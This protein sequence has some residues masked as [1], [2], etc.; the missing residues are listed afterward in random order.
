MIVR[1]R[2]GAFAVAELDRTAYVVSGTLL[3]FDGSAGTLTRRVVDIPRQQ[4][5]V[6]KK[7]DTLLL[8]PESF[9]GRL[10]VLDEH[11]RVLLPARIGVT[12]PEV[13]R[14]VQPG[15]AIWFDDGKIGVSC[16]RWIRSRSPWRSPTLD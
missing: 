3:R 15:E 2:D 16:G 4:T 1:S 8:T 11:D 12:L 10:A 5:L 9:A 6:L 7:G 13:F 14:D